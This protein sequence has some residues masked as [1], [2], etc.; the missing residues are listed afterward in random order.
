VLVAGGDAR[1]NATAPPPELTVG[2]HESRNPQREEQRAPEA[3][4]QSRPIIESWPR[5]CLD[6]RFAPAE[7]SVLR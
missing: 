1:L 5:S 4:E 7:H 2:D 6:Q 3:I